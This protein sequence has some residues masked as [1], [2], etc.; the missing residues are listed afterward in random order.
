MTSYIPYGRQ[1]IDALDKKFV[2]EA[3]FSEKITTGKYVYLFE[4]RLKS[5]LGAKYLKVC[6]NGTA[7][8]H[9]A[10]EALNLKKGDNIIMP[11][12]NF[13]SAYRIAKLLDLNVILIDVDPFTG[14]LDLYK[15]KKFLK[16]NKKKIKAILTM[17]LG[18]YPENINEIIKIKN[19]LK[20]FLIEDGCH[21]LG[22][23]YRI[24]N[25]NYK[26]G[27]GKHADATIF[28]FHPIKTITTAE[29]G[30]VILK[31]KEHFSTASKFIAH[32]FIK[33]SHWHYDIRKLGMN[34]RLSDINCAL[35]I[36]QLKKIKKFIYKREK[37][38]KLYKSFFLNL[39][40]YFTL[41]KYSKEIKPAY[42]LFLLHFNENKIKKNKNQIFRYFLKNKIILQQHYVPINH[43]SFFK[44]KES[45][46]N[47]NKY[48]KTVFSL[49]IY[50]NLSEKKIKLVKKI[51]LKLIK[52][53]K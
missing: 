15:L 18:G 29:G 26:V 7:A 38:Y 49:P 25:K 41:P 3:L 48:I 42:H 46:L 24:D 35:G 37:I 43:F 2:N 36:S 1:S 19:K 40:N 52:I 4:K 20:C 9:L 6:N 51:F 16:N 45:F 44:K 53:N 28:S 22:A 14:Q 50:Y 27:C 30:A 10:Y 32:G 47:A 13:I 34:Y 12:V 5:F 33:K 31:K 21:A 11:V 23:S 8:L 17:Y 39:K